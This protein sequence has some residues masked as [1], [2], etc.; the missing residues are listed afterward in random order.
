MTQ[1]PVMNVQL[2]QSGLRSLVTV[3]TAVTT[4][5]IVLS[6]VLPIFV[7]RVDSL[8]SFI[9]QKTFSTHVYTPI[10][11]KDVPVASFYT[12]DTLVRLFKIAQT[13][14]IMAVMFSGTAFLLSSFQYIMPDQSSSPNGM[15]T[16]LAMPFAVFLII[17]VFMQTFALGAFLSM[18]NR[19]WCASVANTHTVSQTPMGH[20][21]LH[22]GSTGGSCD[23]FSGCVRSFKEMGF[24]RDA[25]FMVLVSSFILSFISLG[26]EAALCYVV[27]RT[28]EP[29]GALLLSDN[30]DEEEHLL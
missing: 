17:A 8:H 12:C 6:W 13:V 10:V 19:S 1:D 5:L 18:Y 9:E 26:V 22:T 11:E 29:V 30:E 16:V 14:S 15:R 4:T 28:R 25:G 24:E 2:V 20:V 21:A 7:L 23:P 27:S 3:L